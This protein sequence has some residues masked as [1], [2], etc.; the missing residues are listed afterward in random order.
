MKSKLI[1]LMLLC[2]GAF[3]M[4]SCDKDTEG[5]TWITYYPDITLEGDA[6][7]TVDKGST[8]VDPGYEATMNGEDVTDQVVVVSNV[9]TANSGVYTVTYSMTNSDGFSAS[10]TRTVIVLDPNN[11]IEGFYDTDPELSDRSGT[12]Y[13]S[14]WQIMLI[15]LGNNLYSVDDLLG[16]YYRDGRGYG[17]SYAM[18]G[19]I[20]I[21]DDGTISLV[22]SYIPG[23][24]DG[25]DDL[26]GTYDA[27]TGTI[28]WVTEYVGYDFHVT[29]YKR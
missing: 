16:G 2:A 28:T 14:S 26:N 20:L 11:P 3:V 12:A 15:G 9:N 4:S 8:F 21:A 6:T 13:G 22:D 29:M 1:Y 7:V 24:G 23:W 18:G 5:K 25:A 10:A 27:A 19:T 17:D